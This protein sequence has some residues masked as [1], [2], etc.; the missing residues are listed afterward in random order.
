ME[1][2]QKENDSDYHGVALCWM[3]ILV[4][5]ISLFGIMQA[6]GK[7]LDLNEYLAEVKE[8][9]LSIQASR[10]RALALKHKI[11][12][13]ATVDDPFIAAGID[14]IPFSGGN[15]KVRRYQISQ[16]IPFPGKLKTRSEIA[17]IR[18]ESSEFD[19]QTVERKIHVLATHTFL[20]ASYNREA[21]ILNE[22]IQKIITETAASAKSRYKT[23]DTS[24]HD[25]LLAKLELSLLNVEFLRLG[26]MQKTLAVLLNELRAMNP[27]S[28][29]EVNYQNLIKIE[30]DSKEIQINLDIQPELRA[31]NSQKN[32]AEKELKLI[33]LSYAP[34]FVIQGMA[35]EPTMKDAEMSEPA[36]WGV[37]V[38]MTIPLFFWRKQ[39]ELVAAAEKDRMATIAD[40]QS[41]QNRFSTEITDAKQQL[42]TSLDLVKLYKNDVIP[43]TEIAVK[44]ARSGY[45]VK[46]MS[47][48]QFLEALRSQRN[49]KLEL[50]AAQMDVIVAKTR[51]Q[52]L[53]ASPP[54]T[55]FA[56]AR[57]TL[58]NSEMNP[59]MGVDDGM[60]TSAVINMGSGMSD[61]KRKKKDSSSSETKAS[62]MG[63]M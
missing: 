40:Y 61:P 5:V 51:I 25:W 28:P 49:Q 57:P 56:P 18:A 20:R 8:A 63:G 31:W 48:R 58:F 52:Q 15:A 2:L 10:L 11:T 4:T 34:D 16:S 3:W 23:G 9:N 35:M 14:E 1:V 59:S 33:K 27:D 42:Q 6:S 19:M 62:G 60:G 47:L 39:S 12:S 7:S 55:R 26:R 32:A 21:M 24:H 46:T 38:G 29:I 13:N 43:I 22:Q 50:F 45:T 54:V 36:S 17:E 53:L 37:M 30:N 41:L 44:N